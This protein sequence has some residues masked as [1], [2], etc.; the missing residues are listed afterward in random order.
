MINKDINNIIQICEEFMKIPSSICSEGPFLNYLK[1]EIEKLG[2]ET[3][4]KKD[5]LV[6]NPQK[7][8]KYLFSAHIDR[9]AVIKNE[10][11]QI[12]HLANYLRKKKGIK[13]RRESIQKT[14]NKLVK[15]INQLSKDDMKLNLDKFFLTASIDNKTIKFLKDDSINLDEMFAVRYVKEEI[16]SYEPKSGKIKNEYKILRYDLDYPNRQIIFETDKKPKITDKYFMM[17]S[18]IIKKKSYFF[19]QIDNAISAAVLFYLLKTNQFEEQIIFTTKEEIADSWRCVDDY[20]KNSKNKNMNLI[21]LDTS[22]Y[23]DLDEYGEGFITL[24]Y[25]D[26]RAGFDKNLVNKIKNK[27]ISMGVSYDFKPSY[28]GRTELGKLAQETNNKINGTTLQLPTKNYHT[29]YETA[30]YKSLKNYYKII[31][32]VISN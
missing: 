2:Y 16:V 23:S 3:Q 5:Y 22:P 13:F 11:G 28:M 24:R 7:N 20:I 1:N 18:S 25:G 32:S 17:K 29:L 14:E 21:V 12:V 6:V 15:K 4:L 27:L 19:G 30:S 8:S 26:E 31:K 10:K 9:H